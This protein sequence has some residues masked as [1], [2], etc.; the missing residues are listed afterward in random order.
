MIRLQDGDLVS[1]GRVEVFC[2]GQ[3]GTVCDRL[4]NQTSADIVCRQLG[5]TEAVDYNHLTAL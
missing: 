5:Y 1:N 2:N 4:F 3:W